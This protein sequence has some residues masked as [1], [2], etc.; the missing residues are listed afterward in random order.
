MRLTEALWEVVYHGWPAGTWAAFWILGAAAARWEQLSRFISPALRDF[1]EK[2][3]PV[4]LLVIAILGPLVW[5]IWLDFERVYQIPTLAIDPPISRQTVLYG[6]ASVEYLLPVRNWPAPGGTHQLA[7]RVHA[8]VEIIDR[9]GWRGALRWSDIPHAGSDV[10]VRVTRDIEFT[11]IE[12]DNGPRFLSLLVY[13]PG[14]MTYLTD[15]LWFT[16]GA[17]T[18]QGVF[19]PF[20]T[21]NFRVELCALNIDEC[22][23]RVVTVE[24]DSLGSKPLVSMVADA[25]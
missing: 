21:W 16:N 20:G 11:D 17:N 4:W 19:L 5:F 22:L 24:I 8:Q 1:V 12:S 14:A 10:N 18:D 25:P 2:L 9:P 15:S 6:N 7:K 23:I 13:R 3:S